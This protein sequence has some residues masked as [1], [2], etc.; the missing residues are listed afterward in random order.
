MKI[1]WAINSLFGLIFGALSVVLLIQ[2]GLNEGLSAPLVRLL[3]YY[4][5]VIEFS[6]TWA[7]P[8]I[9]DFVA[10]LKGWTPI[11]FQFNPWCKYLFTPMWLYFCASAAAVFKANHRI[12]YSIFLAIMGTVIGLISCVAASHWP[13]DTTSILPSLTIVTGFVVFGFG[14]ILWHT[15]FHTPKG[16]SRSVHFLQFSTVYP[17]ANLVIAVGIVGISL[18]SAQLG[19]PIP[20]IVQVLCIV[21]L[22]ALRNFA[23]A[24]YG[25]T[26]YRLPGEGSW[27]TKF[28]QYATFAH[29]R[30]VLAV[31]CAAI[32]FMVLGR[33]LERV[34]L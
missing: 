1:I 7:D 10:F 3:N 6:L 19:Q 28:K 33:G 22:M 13:L 8:F 21:V 24:F 9:K 20:A 16:E 23:A 4:K 34:G 17:V 5:I 26:F 29:G 12:F 11:D 31:I 32:L 30:R 25:A 14:E 2:E 15:A 27:G 18:K